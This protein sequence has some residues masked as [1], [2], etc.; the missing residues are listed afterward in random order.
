VATPNPVTAG[1]YTY[2]ATS[3]IVLLPNTTYYIEAQIGGSFPNGYQ[4]NYTSTSNATSLDGW[5]I[6]GNQH[7]VREPFTPYPM[8]AI[9]ATPR[10]GAGALPIL[11]SPPAERTSS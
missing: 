3:N 10:G 4:W 2:V 8:L 5:E 11:T 7:N 1:I 6:T 9:D